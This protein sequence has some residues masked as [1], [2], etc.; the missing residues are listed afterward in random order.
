M[1]KKTALCMTMMLMICL[2]GCGGKQE[3]IPNSQEQTQSTLE[4]TEDSN[5]QES[6]Q[7]QSSTGATIGETLKNDFVSRITETPDMEP[8]AM[9]EAIL[10]NQILSFSGTTME[11]EEGLLTGFSSEITGFEKGVMFAPMIGS[12]PFVGY[13]FT[14]TDGEDAEAFAALLKEKADPRWNICT[15]ADETVVE[16]SGNMVFFLMCP[17]EFEE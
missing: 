6:T 10:E 3:E 4:V 16:V 14:V 8:Q 5:T 9:A 17:R 11:V 15:Q 1:K 2:I 12:I 13:I 7:T